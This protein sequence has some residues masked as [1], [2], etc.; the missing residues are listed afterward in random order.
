MLNFLKDIKIV[1]L[2]EVDSTNEYLKRNLPDK[3]L[4][5][6]RAHH[7]TAGKGRNGNVWV[8]EPYANV[9]FSLGV[10]LD[11]SMGKDLFY[12]S[13]LTSVAVVETLRKKNV[14]A[15]VKWPND[16]WVKNRKIA[17]ILI[18]NIFMQHK[19]I[20][21]IVGIGLNVNQC[22][23]GGFDATSIKLETGI[24]S[25]TDEVFY[26]LLENWGL[27]LENM[28]RK[29]WEGMD[30]VY[31]NYLPAKCGEEILLNIGGKVQRGVFDRVDRNGYLCVK[32]EGAMKRFDM[33][34]AKWIPERVKM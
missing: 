16:V 29:N 2:D 10:V 21:C 28:M 19:T 3:R 8:S 34:E 7:Q 13:K 23:F 30:E 6:V 11:A 18:E 32:M 4:T 31:H 14:D 22:D 26:S 20:C 17:G 15:F 27:W 9:M 25:D 33:D 5:V 1:C 12:M 24:T